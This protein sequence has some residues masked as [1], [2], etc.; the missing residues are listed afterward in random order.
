MVWSL[1]AALVVVFGGAYAAAASWTSGRIGDGTRVAG[2]EV[3]GLRPVAAQRV[4]AERLRDR[5]ATPVTVTADGEQTAILPAVAGLRVDVAA[6]VDQARAGTGWAP[7]TLWGWFVDHPDLPPVVTVDGAALDRA[8]A[9]FAAVADT[10]ATEGAVTFGAQGGR[11]R[12]PRLGLVIDRDAAATAVRD[13]FLRAAGRDTVAAPVPLPVRVDAPRVDKEAVSRAMDEFA[14]PAL[15]APVVVRLDGEGVQLQPEDFAAALSMTPEDGRL[16]PRL[17]RD[18]LMAAL[19]PQLQRITDAPRDARIE[20]VGGRPRVVPARDG[21]SVDPQEVA[22]GFLQVLG[23]SG[24]AR[25]LSVRSVPAKPRV[26]TAEIRRLG[27][28]ERVSGFTTR[29]PYAAYRNTNLGRAADLI[30][31]TVLR[32]GE[33]FSLNRTVGERTAENGFTRG[34]IIADGVFTR[35]FGGGVSQVATTTFNAAFFAGLTDV[36]HQAHSFYIDRYPVGREA[37]VVWPEVDLR[38]RNDTPYGVLVEASVTRATPSRPGVMRVTMYSTKYWDIRTTT[39]AR[40]ATTPP[41]TR[42]LSGA[43]CVPH[44]G[45]AGFD[46]DVDRLFYRHGTDVLDHRERMHTSYAP[47]DT[48]RCS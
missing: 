32:P 9:S 33:T 4:V 8:V 36:Q 16:R 24:A 21:V 48:V 38:F 41:G 46:V 42:R 22:D 40:Y 28:T 20:V 34:Y 29:F 45:A 12:Y 30:D 6:T 11:A 10:P 43:G 18:A 17:D 5:V 37:T 13:A 31:G 39:S 3:G 19:R 14:N 7:S 26:G 27:I 25:T 1:L 2:V 44:R 23:A 15:S 47:S 35:D